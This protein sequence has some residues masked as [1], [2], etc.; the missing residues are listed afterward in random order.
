MN[1]VFQLAQEF[2]RA[3]NQAQAEGLFDKESLFETFPRGCCGDTCYLLAEYLLEHGICTEYVCGKKGDRSH[4]WLALTDRET[5][6]QK[7]SKKELPMLE[8]ENEDETNVYKHLLDLIKNNKSAKT[9]TKSPAY[10]AELKEQ[11]II[12]ITGDQFCDREEFL[13]YNKQVYVG[14]MDKMHRLFKINN[15]HE[16]RG[17][18]GVGDINEFRLCSLYGKIKK[19]L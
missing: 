1:Q 9:R 14:K 19:Y 8:C 3:M 4:A 18:A 17:L 2:R 12:D 7:I 15:K 16:C 10:E 6:E 13:R 5:L 11:I